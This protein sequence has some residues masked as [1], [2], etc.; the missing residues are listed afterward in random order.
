MAVL[1]D[2]FVRALLVLKINAKY[3]SSVAA[4]RSR[5][6]RYSVTQEN[7]KTNPLFLR[8]MNKPLSIIVLGGGTAGWMAANLMAKRW[9][10]RGVNIRVIESPDIGIIGV[11]EGSTPQLKAFFDELGV[12]E[13]DWMLRCKATYKTGITFRGWSAIPGFEEYFHSFPAKTDRDT[14]QAF[15]YH[16]F[17]RRQNLKV[18]V[19]PDTYFLPAYLA[20]Q[21]RGP[22]AEQNFPFPV[23]Y[24][25]HF[26]SHLLGCFLREKAAEF[27][28]QHRSEKIVDVG[29]G[30]N[31]DIE[32]LLSESGERHHA[33]LF[34]DATGFKSLLLQQAMGVRFESFASNLFNDAAVVLP[35]PA[36]KQPNSQTIATAMSCGWRWDIPLS[37]RTGNGYVYSSEFCSAESAESE[38]RNA[39]EL[40]DNEVEARHLKM[41]VGQ[42]EQHW[43]GNCLAVGLSQG[44]IEP[45]E[46]TALHLVQE[47]VTSFIR[48][49]EASE[50]DDNARD[51]FN[52][53]IRARFEGIRDYIVCHYKVN[54]RADS[55]YWI[56]NRDND[57]LS[58]SLQSIL[59][60]WRRGEDLSEEINRQG[61]AE[62]YSSLSWHSLLSGYGI[63]PHNQAL[64]EGDPRA[65]RFDTDAVRD[66]NT[67]SALNFRPHAEQLASLGD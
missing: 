50:L 30:H 45:L 27:G 51:N 35:S 11:G 67:R 59:Q 14:A 6:Y 16:C 22:L 53:Q 64:V 41:R 24:G 3:S 29:L 47:T 39:L 23:S 34:V 4:W 7:I 42:V 55:D 13:S 43:S 17:L 19:S 38:L 28:V 56:A 65:Q 37:H 10:G 9:Q 57:N 48:A 36:T 31:G 5:F 46:A 18:E 25:Y 52:A 26:D 32:S 60:V 44:F 63:F 12:A 21:K 8:N 40:E 15:V 62:Y 1:I 58:D 61:I 54:S 20:K 2:F 66:F 33:D 49:Y